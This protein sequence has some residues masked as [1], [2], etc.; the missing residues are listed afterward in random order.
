M[1][2]H[3]KILLLRIQSAFIILKV[4]RGNWK[5]VWMHDRVYCQSVKTIQ[6]MQ[7][8]P[9]TPANGEALDKFFASMTG[10]SKYPDETD[11]QFRERMQCQLINFGKSAE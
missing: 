1:I 11:N 10:I 4:S 5:A 9:I 3:L 2:K 7:K 8:M 6:M